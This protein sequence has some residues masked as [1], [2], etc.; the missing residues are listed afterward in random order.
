MT[1]LALVAEPATRDDVWATWITLF[2]VI[3]VGV[4]IIIAKLDKILEK[5]K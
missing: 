2:F 1:L 5:L 3:G 4:A